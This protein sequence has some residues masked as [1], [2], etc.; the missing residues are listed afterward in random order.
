MRTL[1]CL[2]TAVG[3]ANLAVAYS[4]IIDGAMAD[5]RIYYAIAN[6]PDLAVVLLPLPIGN[7]RREKSKPHPRR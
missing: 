3:F 1:A 7:M 2:L 4:T 6:V 5:V